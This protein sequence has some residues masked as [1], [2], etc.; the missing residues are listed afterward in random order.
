MSTYTAEAPLAP[1]RLSHILPR[2][3]KSLFLLTIPVT[4]AAMA[5]A[6]IS[7]DDYKIQ[8]Q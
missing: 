2:M 5:I 8:M 7:D 6:Q 4:F 1:G 3:R